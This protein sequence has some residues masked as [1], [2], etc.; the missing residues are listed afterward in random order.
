MVA[1]ELENEL[2]ARYPREAP[3]MD[4]RD[5]LAELKMNYAPR[6]EA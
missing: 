3:T 1:D 4:Y 6:L 5:K 2:V